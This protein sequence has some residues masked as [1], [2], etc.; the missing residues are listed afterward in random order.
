MRLILYIILIAL[1][2][3]YLC[4][5]AYTIYNII[6]FLVTKELYNIIT[7]LV[8]KELTQKEGNAQKRREMK[9]KE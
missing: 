7:F 2:N 3:E 1:I 6:T 4:Y 8:T 9:S 5:A